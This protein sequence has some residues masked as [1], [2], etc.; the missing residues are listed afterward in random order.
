MGSWVV[1]R[2]AEMTKVST[3]IVISLSDLT[4]QDFL[5]FKKCRPGASKGVKDGIDVFC[6]M[7]S[8]NNA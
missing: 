2:A 7:T 1:T 5:N 8:G 4:V 3:C 6:V